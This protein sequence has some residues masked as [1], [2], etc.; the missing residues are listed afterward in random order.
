MGA[1][2]SEN[3]YDLGSEILTNVQRSQYWNSRFARS[4]SDHWSIGGF[5]N[6][7]SSLFS[8][9]KLFASVYP[10]IEYNVYPYSESS[11]H[12][13]RLTY[14]AGAEQRYYNDT[15]IYNKLNESLAGNQ[16]SVAYMVQEKW[17]SITS[18]VTGTAYFHDF[19]QNS[20][21]F[22]TSVDVR[23]FKGFSFY[24]S[25]NLS[26]IRNQLN[27]V[28]GDA[29]DADILLQQRN[30]ASSYTYW[31]NAG[32]TYTFGSIYNSIVNPRFND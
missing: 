14:H 20:L 31:G 19:S 29:S 3:T 26:L 16:L 2:Y 6:A 23:L 5:A 22:Y 32:F 4:I 13:M 28:K 15:T 10:G 7:S 27:L 25:G 1:N 21:R 24:F 30:I 11:K 18:S 12:Q 17:G 9:H 8:N